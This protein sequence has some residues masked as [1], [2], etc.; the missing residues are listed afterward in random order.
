MVVRQPGVGTTV[1]AL[2]IESS[3][4]QV[5]QQLSD[6]HRYSAVTVAQLLAK[7][8]VTVKDPARCDL[9]QAEPGET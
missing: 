9:M 5:M 8:T 7:E 3:Y 1:K 4:R 6:L 2:R